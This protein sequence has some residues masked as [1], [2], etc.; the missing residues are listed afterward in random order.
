M[1]NRLL[2]ALAILVLPAALGGCEKKLD[3]PTDPQVCWSMAVTKDGKVKFNKVAEHVPDLEHCAAQL[4]AMRIKFL[5]LGGTQTEI[6]GEYQ[7]SFLFLQREG[8]FTAQSYEGA[9][10]PFM[11]RTG[12]GRLAVPGAMPQQ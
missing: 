10:Y 4:E 7:G 1:R 2:A 8:V 9:R 5:S 11:V 12:D 3:A 6:T